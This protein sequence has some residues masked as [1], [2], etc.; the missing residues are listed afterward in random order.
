MIGVV[1]V[2]LVISERPDAERG[3]AG[4]KTLLNKHNRLMVVLNVTRVKLVDREAVEFLLNRNT[5]SDFH[6]KSGKMIPSAAAEIS[7]RALTSPPRVDCA[8]NESRCRRRSAS[9]PLHEWSAL[10]LDV[11]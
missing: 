2:A 1:M 7:P 10:G 8:A 6:A 11:V 5:S 4:A 3:S 9:S